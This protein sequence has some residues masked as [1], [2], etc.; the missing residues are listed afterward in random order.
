MKT[1]SVFLTVI[2]CGLLASLLL[3]CKKETIKTAP[4][5]TISAATSIT[6]ISA[7][8]EGEIT[9]DGGASVTAR[10]ICWSTSQNPTTA[11]SKT[12]NGVGTG[13]FTSP[14][15]GLSPGITYNLKSYAT[16]SVGTG[17]SN[18]SSFTT[19][20]LAPVLTT[21]EI[22]AITSVSAS[23]G[24]NITNDG[25]SP[26]TSRGICWSTTQDPTISSFKTTDGTG[27]GSFASS[28]TALTP[29]TAYYIRSYATN[30][31][32]TAYGN[33]IT[34][35]TTAIMSVLTTTA[36][37]S[38]TA[39]TVT[40]GG[41]ITNDGG[42]AVTARGVCWSTSANPT[43]A[44]SKTSDATGS[45]V[46]TS[47]ITGLTPGTAYFV[48]AYSTNS[49]G[50]TYGNEVTTTT[51][52]ALPVITTTTS[53]S[54]MATSLASGGNI[55]SDGGS[56]VTTRGVCWSTSSNPTTASSKTT[57]ATGTGI[58]T[59]SITGLTPGAT[60]YFRAY[61]TNS[62]GTV[63][64]N[65]II[66]TLKAS[67]PIL[68]TT[69]ASEIESVSVMSGGFISSDGGSAVTS[70][71]VCWSTSS[72]PTISG[73]KTKDA[74]ERGGFT[75]LI[76]GLSAITTYYIRSYATNS[77]GTAYG[78][79]ISVTTIT[80]LPL[81]TTTKVSAI[82]ATTACS[83]GN[84]TSPGNKIYGIP[85]G[86]TILEQGV[87]WSSTPTPSIGNSK[88]YGKIGGNGI[89]SFTCTAT[90]LTPNTTYYMR[91]YAT[92]D[93]GTSYGSEVSF[94]T[95]T[96]SSEI[97]NDIDGNAYHTVAIGTQ[98]WMVEN[99]KTTKYRNGEPITNITGNTE[100]SALTSEGYCFYK[101]DATT[102]KASYGVLYN[103]YSATDSRNIAPTGWHVP[104]DAEW[105]TL[106]TFLISEMIGTG[107]A[108]KET[109]VN[110]WLYPN[111]NATNTSHFTALPGGARNNNGIFDYIGSYGYWWSSTEYS[112]ANSWIQYLYYL[113]GID[114]RSYRTKNYGLSVRCIQD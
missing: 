4:T 51:T 26:I 25:G 100:W 8:V 16:N 90:G 36:I 107:S 108:L 111:N 52:A 61:A 41:N 54:I 23:S 73:L 98:L 38:I 17:Y 13:S 39:T 27:P 29:G 95:I 55:T 2:L 30:S 72:N 63:Y 1:Q 84:V 6:A 22:S 18:Q 77:V 53:S 110:H 43:T 40:S 75:S 67:I 104:T 15:I 81:I 91:A 78:N 112:S 11:D 48:R 57:D 10:G 74:M 3:N 69:S 44:S 68:T 82:T 59:S 80:I 60:Y 88:T 85:G 21:I 92:N 94:K 99:L 83:G 32:G 62:I 105:K 42:S 5:A 96:T 114:Y 24:G 31:I 34:A 56:V 47:S 50:T 35:T 14:I 70:C 65:E 113:D 103:W 76:N 20:A 87:C 28:I 33:Q 58:F 79:Q 89:G 66:S 93:F 45:G 19:L 7:S 64:G 46:F 106:M 102:Y 37:S 71:G 49:I 12:T 86:G 97:V 109:G 9:A 101:N